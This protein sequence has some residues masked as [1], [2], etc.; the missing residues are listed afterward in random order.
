MR[1]PQ[2][3]LRDIDLIKTA[4]IKEF[5]SFHDNAFL[6]GLENDLFLPLNPS[7][8]KGERLVPITI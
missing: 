7:M 3:L 4:L 5:T 1:S 6:T 8:A 2:L